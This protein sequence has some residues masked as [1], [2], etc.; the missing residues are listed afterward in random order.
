MADVALVTSSFLPRIGGVEE[1]VRQV[2]IQLRHSGLDVVVWT[3]DQG[4][5]VPSHVEGVR[6]RSLPCPLPARN[7]RSLAT[8]VWRGPIAA[9]RWLN[10]LR[11]DR[12]AVLN[13]QCFGP[14]GVWATA[15]A[16][17]TRR[18]LVITGHGETVG[19]ADGAFT[20]SALLRRSL[21]W[22][23]RR[24]DAVTA[25]SRHAELD[26]VQSFGLP[27]GTAELIANGVDLD[28]P[29]AAPPD[30]LPSR[31]FFALGRLVENK[32]F[33]LLVRAFAAADLPTDIALVIG[34]TGPSEHS[35]RELADQLGVG[36]RLMLPGRLDPGQ[37][38]AI[39]EGA[40]AVVVPSRVE[41]FGIVVLEGWRA[42]V[43]VVATSHGGPADLVNDGID[44]WVVDP[45]DT[46]ALAMTLR[47][48]V[49]D[50]VRAASI[51]AAGRIKA[52]EFSWTRVAAMYEGVYGQLLA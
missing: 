36:E 38:V 46:E 41:S 25:C 16:R 33:D 51:A 52:A 48:V 13:V 47:E 2:A 28:E 31:Y 21:R 7:L 19:D 12:P 3:V 24:A 50:P 14:N 5:D 11:V 45:L 35:L 23:L 27:A 17:L 30:G 10:A 26:L 34:G 32:G 44:G 20:S 9:V 15:M 4:D 42:E 40:E 37:V 43:P 6:I 1:H 29:A 18:R 22:A 39:A 49:A 8:F